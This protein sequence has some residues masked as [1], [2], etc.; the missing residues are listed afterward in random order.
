MRALLATDGSP[1]AERATAWLEDF[2][3]AQPECQVIVMH[4]V[5]PLV[6]WFVPLPGTAPVRAQT[7][8]MQELARRAVADG[9]ELV[10]RVAAGFSG[11]CAVT[12]LVLEGDPARELTRA[13]ESESANVIVIGRRGLGPIGE[14][15]LGSV[16]Q[17]VLHSSKVPVLVVP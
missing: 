16:T 4:V 1:G 15:L 17:R 12:T 11:R 6:Y 3:G 5:R 8:A 14:L 13:A 10:A 2:V 9:E 7:P